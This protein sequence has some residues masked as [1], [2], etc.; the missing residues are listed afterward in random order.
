MSQHISK[1]RSIAKNCGRADESGGSENVTGYL[2]RGQE[3]K[4]VMNIFG[5]GDNA[6]K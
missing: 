3:R 6:I 5:Q 4:N 2:T 1:E